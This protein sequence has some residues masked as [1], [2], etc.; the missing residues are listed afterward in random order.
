MKNVGVLFRLHS[1]KEFIL[2]GWSFQNIKKL[3]QYCSN[4]NIK[5]DPWAQHVF[6]VFSMFLNLL[7]EIWSFRCG[8]LS[9]P[10]SDLFQDILVS[11]SIECSMIS[12]SVCLLVEYKETTDFLKLIL[13]PT[14]LLK[15][16]IVS[17]FLAEFLL[18]LMYYNISSVNKDNLTS[19][20]SNL[21]FNFLLLFYC[22]G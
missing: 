19:F 18:S 7:L 11:D 4:D 15:L 16:C 22:C 20:F 12:F 21:C 17:N 10:S 3:L 9:H 13:Y 14:T 1:V 6:P 2:V 5:T 8:D